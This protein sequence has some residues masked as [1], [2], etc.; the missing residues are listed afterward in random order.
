MLKDVPPRLLIATILASIRQAR[1]LV[2][3]TVWI[4]CVIGWLV[5]VKIP[6]QYTVA[7]RIYVDTDSVLRPLMQGI[8]VQDDIYKQVDILRRTL[9]ARPNMEELLRKTD[10]DLTVHTDRDREALVA[11][12]QRRIDVRAPERQLYHITFT[13]SD[14]RRALSVVQSLINIFVEQNVG[15]SRRDV[16]KARRFIDVQIDE[17]EGRLRVEE[18]KLA[19]FRRAHGA[20]LMV[21][22]NSASNAVVA[23]NEVRRLDTELQAA[24]WR[25]DQTRADLARTPAT[26]TGAARERIQRTERLS[27]PQA[28]LKR[29]QDDLQVALTSRTEKHPDIVALRRQIETLQQAPSETPLPTPGDSGESSTRATS[30]AN[31][32]HAQLASEARKADQEVQVL[33]RRLDVARVH[34]ESTKQKMQEVPE[35]EQQL[36][37]LNRDY[38]ILRKKYDELVMRRESAQMSQRLEDQTN[39]VDF[40]LVDPPVLPIRAAGPNRPLLFSGVF[41]LALGLGLGLPVLMMFLRSGFLHANQVGEAF[42]L[43]VLGSVTVVARPSDWRSGAEIPVYVGACASL[44]VILGG[45]IYLYQFATA[46]PDLLGFAGRLM[47]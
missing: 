28:Q 46:E 35:I 22:Q 4:V 11:E 33:Q 38:D 8:A 30:M 34:W 1:W 10:M 45:L 44:A 26:L 16:E 41:V 23:E 6:S 5:V 25:R 2:L 18:A 24:I 21:R 42:D 19:E 27:E 39:R 29:L 43:P 7:T 14:P 32:I 3:A 40:R 13:D 9:L 31:P 37:Q 17:Y 20:E 36:T 47:G 12:M 15:M